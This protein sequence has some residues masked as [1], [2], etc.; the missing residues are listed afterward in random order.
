MVENAGF[1][2]YPQKV[3]GKLDG[4]GE[5]SHKTRFFDLLAV[6]NSVG[7]VEKKKFSTFI[8]R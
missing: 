7:N 8:S 4:H 2:H 6:E 5:K 1:P 3:C